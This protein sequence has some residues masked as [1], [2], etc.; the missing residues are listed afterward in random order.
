[1][2]WF[3]RSEFDRYADFRCDSAIRGGFQWD[4][5]C[6][7]ELPIP[8]IEKQREIVA[9][10]NTITNRI[11]LNEQLNQKLEETAQALYKH[12]F[13]D[14]EFPN[15]EGKPYK[16][17]GGDMV[18]CDELDKEIPEGWELTYLGE[19][20]S[21]K[22]YIR[23]PFGSSLK[24][25][26]MIEKGVPVYEQQHAIDNH[27]NFRYFISTEK[28]QTLKR[29]T[30]RPDDLVISCSGTLGRIILIESDDPIGVINQAL[31]ILSPNKSKIGP[32]CFQY[33][34]TSAI[35]NSLL[36]ENSA[37]SAQVNMAKR[38]VIQSIPFL[39]PKEKTR[40]LLEM[41][42]SKIYRKNVT[43]NKEIDRLIEFKNILLSKM[44]KIEVEKEI[45]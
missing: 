43:L 11:A 36:I 25:D 26:D 3:R 13:V 28:H 22:G 38:E 39:L 37:G 15:E 41:N 20:L 30:V 9:E 27:R 32:I 44:T 24:K 8:S 34:L 29:F 23:G 35:G 42:L 10:Y 19:L 1:M 18:W 2:M 21:E 14:F 4:E 33:F 45:V 17:S 5:L 40:N 6:E 7:T 12:W 31:L 16:S